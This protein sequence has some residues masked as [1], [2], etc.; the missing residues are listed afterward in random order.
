M[1]GAQACAWKRF[2]IYATV[3]INLEK[4]VENELFP[5]SAEESPRNLILHGRSL[6]YGENHKLSTGLF[7]VLIYLTAFSQMKIQGRVTIE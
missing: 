7:L 1:I 4:K 3:S 2:E 6:D 5:A